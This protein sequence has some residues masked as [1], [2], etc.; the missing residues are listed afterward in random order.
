MRRSMLVETHRKSPRGQ[1]PE[2]IASNRLYS[3]VERVVSCLQP[4]D[5][6]DQVKVA[7][8]RIQV[9]DM[10]PLH[11]GDDGRVSECEPFVTSSS[12]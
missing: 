8:K 11:V 10:H 12:P 5:A 9:L 2:A 4:R 3:S 1:A 6:V 7:V